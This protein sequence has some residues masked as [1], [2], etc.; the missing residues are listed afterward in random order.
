M[1]NTYATVDL[2]THSSILSIATYSGGRLEPIYERLSPI[3]MGHSFVEG[4]PLEKE[5]TE[6][7]FSVL[8]EY[9]QSLTACF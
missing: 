3:N 2:G 1:K 9:V 8:K 5:N 6:P 4:Q 7:L